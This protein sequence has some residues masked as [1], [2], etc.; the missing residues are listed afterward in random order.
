MKTTVS[1][2]TTAS[3]NVLYYDIVN[4]NILF[5]QRLII[6]MRLVMH[7]NLKF[8]QVINSHDNIRF[9]SSIY[10]FFFAMELKIYKKNW[11]DFLY[12]LDVIY[13]IQST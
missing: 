9:V 1:I 11:F 3:I 4:L 13:Y 12:G 8:Y 6:K 5:S 2:K 7:I 10:L